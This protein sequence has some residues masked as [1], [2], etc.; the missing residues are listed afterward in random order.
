MLKN[1]LLALC[2][3]GAAPLVLADASLEFVDDARGAMQTRIAVA[4]DK[5]RV[6]AAGSGG[7]YV[8]LDLRTQ[9]LTQINPQRRTTTS[10]TV[11]EVQRIISTL[12]S[13]GDPST[14]PL[15]QLALGS[16]PSQQRAQLERMLAQSRRD[17][18]FPYTSN[19][20][21]E[22]VNEIPC[23]V[24]VQRSPTG[25][26]RSLCSARYADLGLAT[27]DARTLQT[28]ME[29]LRRTGGPWLRAAQVPGLPIRYAGSFDRGAFSGAGHLQKLAKTPLPAGHFSDPPGYRIVSILEMLASAAPPPR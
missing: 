27:A 3:A 6:D 5:L 2:F 1:L 17:A 20:V 29:L 26:T 28:A 13:A 7:S 10:S 12:S 14:Q 22:R 18:E 9:T 24:F 25:D 4:G 21:L 19:G 11:E 23:E 15:L 8:V 16:L